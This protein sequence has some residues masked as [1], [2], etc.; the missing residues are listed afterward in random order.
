MASGKYTGED[1][2]DPSTGLK[3]EVRLIQP[4]QAT[5]PYL[6]PACAQIIAERTAHYVVVPEESPGLRRHWHRHCWERPRGKVRR[7]TR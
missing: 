3:A 4:Y 5:K 1:F 6:C 2:E 7:V